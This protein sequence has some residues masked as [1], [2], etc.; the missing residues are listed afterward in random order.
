[1]VGPS[2]S[3]PDANLVL[4]YSEKNGSLIFRVRVVPRAS[5]SEIVGEHDGA[6]RVRI[7][8]PPV[9]GAANEELVR[10][11]ASTFGASRRDIEITAG[12]SSKLKTVRVAGLQAATLLNACAPQGPKR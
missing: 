10:L 4:D 5:R 9:E 12:Q 11:L 8:A 2:C 1:M 6:M 7:A 3:L